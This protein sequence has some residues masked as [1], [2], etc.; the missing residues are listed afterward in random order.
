MGTEVL[1]LFCIEKPKAKAKTD[2]FKY[3]E[4]FQ[5]RM[6]FPMFFTMLFIINDQLSLVKSADEND[7][8]MMG[9][10]LQSLALLRGNRLYRA[11][12]LQNY[13]ENKGKG[14]K[15][16]SNHSLWKTLT[17]GNYHNI[18]HCLMYE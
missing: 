9:K 8:Q 5:K 16:W 17:K 4:G 1:F 2:I 7:H 10:R 6:F 18:P 11:E 12:D 13:Y 14:R 3:L 15:N